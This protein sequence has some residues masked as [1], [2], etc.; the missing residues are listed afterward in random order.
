MTSSTSVQVTTRY[1]AGRS[2]LCKDL[3]SHQHCHQNFLFTWTEPVCHQEQPAVTAYSYIVQA[4]D[5][6]DT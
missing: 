1:I 6:L 5:G 3:D 4:M 2:A